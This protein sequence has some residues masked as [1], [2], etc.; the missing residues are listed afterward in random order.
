MVVLGI[1]RDRSLLLLMLGKTEHRMT[2]HQNRP[3][4]PVWSV[5]EEDFQANQLWEEGYKSAAD[6]DTR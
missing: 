6:Q 2:E 1:A 4:S 3:V 5:P